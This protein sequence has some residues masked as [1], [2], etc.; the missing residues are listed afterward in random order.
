MEGNGGCN[1]QRVHGELGP[2]RWR[3]PKGDTVNR[4]NGTLSSYYL[5]QKAPASMVRLFWGYLSV[6][7][8]SDDP[9]RS[10]WSIDYMAHPFPGP[11]AA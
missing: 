7:E 3:S 1:T 9:H 2:Y 10:G 8:I 4:V 5:A 11:L 6:E